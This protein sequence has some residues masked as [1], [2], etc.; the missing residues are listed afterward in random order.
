M[1]GMPEGN[2]GAEITALGTILAG[3][4]NKEGKESMYS[5]RIVGRTHIINDT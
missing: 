5:R 2:P 4:Y 3:M 1:R